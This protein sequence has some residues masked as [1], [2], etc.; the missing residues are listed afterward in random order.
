[1]QSIR[2]SAI[3]QLRQPPCLRRFQLTLT[4]DAIDIR[5]PHENFLLTLTAKTPEMLYS[6]L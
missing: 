4:P 1:M 6:C 2:L 5:D 3:A